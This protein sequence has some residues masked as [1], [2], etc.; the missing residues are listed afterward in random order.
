MVVPKQPWSILTDRPRKDKWIIEMACKKY[1]LNPDEIITQ[2]TFL[3][4]FNSREESANWKSSILME[5]LNDLFIVDVIYVDDDPEVL[6][7]ITKQPGLT[8]CNS[9]TLSFILKEINNGEG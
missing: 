5:A 3:Y 1:K 7:S 8:L 9:K 6:A 4:R 2:P